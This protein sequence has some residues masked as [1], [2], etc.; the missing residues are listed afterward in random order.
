MPDTKG[1][2][3]FGPAARAVR[4]RALRSYAEESWPAAYEGIDPEKNAVR[5]ANDV[6]HAA[7]ADVPVDDLPAAIGRLLGTLAADALVDRGVEAGHLVSDAEVQ[8][9]IDELRSGVWRRHYG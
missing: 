2:N 3:P 4:G 6:V 7:L 5:I 9:L 1:S 8:T